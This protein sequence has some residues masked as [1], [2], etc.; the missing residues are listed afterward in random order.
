LL[1]PIAPGGLVTLFGS[2]FTYAPYQAD[3]IPLAT[4]M[5]GTTVFVDNVAVPLLYVSPTQINFQLPWGNRTGSSRLR[6]NFGGVETEITAQVSPSAPAIFQWRG[7]RGVFVN[8]DFT[9]NVPENPAP[10]G[11]VVILYLNSIG[12]VSPAV[13][14][15]A[16]SPTSVPAKGI[17][18]PIVTFGGVRGTVYFS[19]LAPGFVGVWQ[20]NV[21]VPASAPTGEVPV[22]VS[23]SQGVSNTAMISTQ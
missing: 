5:G 20:L 21:Q 13:A 1:P 6:V 7:N 18:T 22:V 4:T 23:T 14:D 19:G 9:L 16:A 17:E 2:G 8:Q 12:P 3:A 10:R 15:G 11:S